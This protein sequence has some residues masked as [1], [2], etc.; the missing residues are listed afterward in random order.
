MRSFTYSLI[1]LSTLFALSCTRETPTAIEQ[2]QVQLS[3]EHVVGKAP[4]QLGSTA[5]TNAG[6][7]TFTV[8]TLN[9]YVT[10]IR[11]QRKDGSNYVV[12]QDSSY[13]LVRA[14]DPA[15]QLITLRHIPVGEYTGVSY[16]LGVD[17]LRNTLGVDRR[18]GVLDPAGGHQGGM[19]W[20]W[21]SGYIHFKLEGTSPQAPASANGNT[22]FYHIGLFGGYQA[23]TLN[24]LRRITLPL[25]NTPLQVVEGGG[26]PRLRI[27]ADVQKVFD[28]PAP[29]RI[30]QTPLIMVSDLSAGVANNYAQMFR[31]IGQSV[32]K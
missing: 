7:E 11:L 17:S 21:N 22:Y 31:V 16:L 19:Y 4:L 1:G 15:T 23:R 30:T 3:F 8:S 25:G 12:P 28:G 24:N 5:Y 6:G 9:Y 26:I 20:D 18:K 10:N 14:S 27:E 29:L 13:F 32:E 2:G